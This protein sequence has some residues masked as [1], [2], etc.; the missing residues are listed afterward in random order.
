[1]RPPS[2]GGLIG[3]NAHFHPDRISSPE[4]IMSETRPPKRRRHQFSLRALLIAVLA[5]G[6][7][8]DWLGTKL[9]RARK[10]RKAAAGHGEFRESAETKLRGRHSRRQKSPDSTRTVTSGRIPLPSAATTCLC[11]QKSPTRFIAGSSS[12][13]AAISLLG[14]RFTEASS[15]H[16]ASSSLAQMAPMTES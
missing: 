13:P 12:R 15:H 14:R 5:L 6:V 11:W 7:L 2:S 9:Q 1:M 16:R 8:F 10:K 4:A 3:L